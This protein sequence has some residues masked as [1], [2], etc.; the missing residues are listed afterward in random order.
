M[1]IL[2]RLQQDTLLLVSIEGQVLLGQLAQVVFLNDD[3]ELLR[4]CVTILAM[5]FHYV[6]LCETGMGHCDT[7][8]LVFCLGHLHPLREV[9]RSATKKRKKRKADTVTTRTHNGS[10]QSEPPDFSGLVLFEIVLKS[11][12]RIQGLTDVLCRSPHDRTP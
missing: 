8:N 12:T 4:V 11:L 7:N 2:L 9:S 3:L 1:P 10:D 6:L 5:L